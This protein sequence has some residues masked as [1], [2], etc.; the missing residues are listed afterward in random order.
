[1]RQT[2]LLQG[3]VKQKHQWVEKWAKKG[4]LHSLVPCDHRQ[5]HG[6]SILP[7]S[8]DSGWRHKSLC[9]G[10]SNTIQW[11]QKKVPTVLQVLIHG[12]TALLKN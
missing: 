8:A 7:C 1:M 2:F 4:T 10:G 12:L 9:C 5:Y 11:R 3:K 6:Y